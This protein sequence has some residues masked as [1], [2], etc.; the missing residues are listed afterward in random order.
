MT[1]NEYIDQ[2]FAL[3][4][5]FNTQ[6][7]DQYF[8]DDPSQVTYCKLTLVVVSKDIMSLVMEAAWMDGRTMNYS[9]QGNAAWQHKIALLLLENPA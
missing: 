4:G 8:T 3:L 6:A 1:P 2:N 5:Q 9:A 7:S